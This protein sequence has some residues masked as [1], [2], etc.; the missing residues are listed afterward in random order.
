M[1]S[2]PL[3]DH[4]STAEASGKSYGNTTIDGRARAHLG[5]VNISGGLHLHK[6]NLGPNSSVGTRL[7]S[8]IGDAPDHTKAILQALYFREEHYRQVQ[9]RDAHVKTFGRIFEEGSRS[10]TTSFRDWL[11]GGGHCF[12]VNGKAG[13]GKSTLMK[14]VHQHRLLPELLQI[15]AGKRM[16]LIASFFFWHAGQSL[17]KSYEGILRSILHQV[18]EKWPGLM[19]VVFPRMSRY[20]T[21]ERDKGISTF[22]EQELQEATTNLVRNLPEDLALFLLIDGIDEYSGDH[23]EFSKFLVHISRY[24]YVKVLAASRPIPACHQA[25]SRLP[26]LRLQDLTAQDIRAYINEELVSDDLFQEMDCPESGFSKDI[27]EA[28]VNKAS[29]VFLWIILVVRSLL[30]GLGNY[31]NRQTLMKK[32]DELPPDLEALYDHMFGKMSQQYQREGSTLLQ[33]IMH[34]R[35]IQRRP[36]TALQL[37]IVDRYLQGIDTLSL[38]AL[39]GER[40]QSLRVKAIEGKLRS[41]CCGLVEVRYYRRH[42]EPSSEPTVDFLHQ[43]V[44]DYLQDPSVWHKLLSVCK[45]DPVQLNLPL[46]ASCEHA[47]RSKAD[48]FPILGWKSATT[49]FAECLAYSYE[50]SHLKDIKYVDYIEAADKEF[51][52]WCM[53]KGSSCTAYWEEVNKI[54]LLKHEFAAGLPLSW[55]RSERTL[56]YTASSLLVIAY[57][58]FAEYFQRKFPP[59]I[60]DSATESFVLLC[61]LDLLGNIPSTSDL[62]QSYV[63]NVKALL[64]HG[65]DPNYAMEWNMLRG[66]RPSYLDRAVELSLSL[67]QKTTPWN[68]W[69]MA[70]E[71]RPSHLDVTLQ[72]LDAGAQV[73]DVSE[74]EMK[75]L[76]NLRDRLEDFLTQDLEASVRSTAEQIIKYLRPTAPNKKRRVEMEVTPI[77]SIPRS[78]KAKKQRPDASSGNS[79]MA[80]AQRRGRGRAFLSTDTR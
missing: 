52:Q 75:A 57:M 66:G 46:L 43:T 60:R 77:A 62:T 74:P 54:I 36:I 50:L 29:G 69:L 15:W 32:V 24:P 20:L 14:I 18:L 30:V 64:S 65:V 41:R 39:S 49:A 55:Y 73:S 34:A 72:L 33:L 70:L 80:A 3:G 8:Y 28:L 47:M 61:L 40:E 1:A 11:K 48:H 4:E 38:P 21:L 7:P 68:V 12:W 78:K 2:N 26:S 10:S 5:D 13:S 71:I 22:S 27:T 42:S 51:Y 31:E 58:G 44:T 37:F 16:V 35:S 59:R 53:K 76:W 6:Y 17:Q 9:V 45:L 25:F 23:F 63:R 79:A 67:R 56:S 19:P